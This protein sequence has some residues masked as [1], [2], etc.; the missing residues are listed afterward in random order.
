[1]TGLA[2]PPK[3]AGFAGLRPCVGSSSQGQFRS[4]S[5]FVARWP[6]LS[7]ASGYGERDSRALSFPASPKAGPSSASVAPVQRRHPPGRFVLS[8]QRRWSICG[9]CCRPVRFW[10]V[11]QPITSDN[12]S[13]MQRSSCYKDVAHTHID[14]DYKAPKEKPFHDV[15]AHHCRLFSAVQFFAVGRIPPPAQKTW[16]L[17]ATP[18]HERNDPHAGHH[19]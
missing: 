10:R 1:M 16:A 15:T 7:I 2:R 12:P 3:G 11:R 9:R 14:F 13:R 6:I 19:V 8:A 4:S 17:S 18:G 5:P